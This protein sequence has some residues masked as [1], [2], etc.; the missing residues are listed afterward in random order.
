MSHALTADTFFPSARELALEIFALLRDLDPA[1]WREGLATAARERLE[2]VSAQLRELLDLAPSGESF[3][4]LRERLGELAGILDEYTPSLAA[5]APRETWMRLRGLLVPRYDALAQVLRDLE[6]HVPSLR[7]TNYKR[8]LFHVSSA[9]L[10]VLLV[11]VVL[12]QPGL[13]KASAAFAIWA[14]GCE[15]VR[16]RSPAVNRALMKVM[17]PV[18]HPHE[19]WRINSATWYATAVFLLAL[20]GEPIVQITGVA[21]LGAADPLAAIVGRRYGRHKLVN[22]RSL[23]GSLTFVAAG[24]LVTFALLATLHPLT[25]AQAALVALGGALPGSLAELFSRRIDDNFSIPL[26]AAGGA[27]LTLHLLG[28][29]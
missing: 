13:V 6:V 7:P 17:G 11:E 18:A 8:N 4:G 20:T 9:L 1:G 5:G 19:H 23:E 15:I 25:P 10:S 3:I 26:T 16:R 21:V 2:R 24:A 29:G 12:T 22:G 27:L 28:L 14:W